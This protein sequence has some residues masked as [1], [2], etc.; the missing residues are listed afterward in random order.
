MS[1]FA[2]KPDWEQK[3]VP[4]LAPAPDLQLKAPAP[5]FGIAAA[6]QLLRGLPNDNE[7]VVRVVRAT[8]ASLDVHLPE[9]I[10]DATR[11][12]KA[13]SDRITAVHAQM[14]E[15]ERQLENHRREIASLEADLKETTSVKE[16][17]QMAEK[18]AGLATA[19]APRGGL[20]ARSGTV[21]TPGPELLSK[22][23][24]EEVT[25]TSLKD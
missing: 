12:Q 10:E 15:L 4:D 3:G 2:K 17:L 25:A 21:H 20:P 18:T 19:G 24:Q 23:P 1:I 11:R 6:I 9:I 13:A 7:L 16:R 22:S 14:A 5:K 8:L